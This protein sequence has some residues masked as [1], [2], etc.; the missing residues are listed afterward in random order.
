VGS[1]VRDE[2]REVELGSVE[3]VERRIALSV[4]VYATLSEPATIEPVTPVRFGKSSTV[5]SVNGGAVVGIEVS[6]WKMSFM[7]WKLDING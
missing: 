6:P 7:K 3:S 5:S 4:S 2:V 1:E